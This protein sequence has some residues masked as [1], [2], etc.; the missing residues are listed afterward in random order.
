MVLEH[1]REKITNVTPTTCCTGVPIQ[2][3]GP[4][5]KASHVMDRRSN[6]VRVP[7]Q[8]ITP[9]SELLSRAVCSPRP[10]IATAAWD[11]LIGLWQ[12]AQ[13]SIYCPPH[14]T[15]RDLRH[16]TNS[17][18]HRMAAIASRGALLSWM[19]SLISFVDA[20]VFG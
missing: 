5:T 12:L 16:S 11:T 2:R 18:L 19:K 6:D 17:R 8:E 3:L 15:K 9:R 13:Q 4:R 20:F 10:S 1:L 14:F 7:S